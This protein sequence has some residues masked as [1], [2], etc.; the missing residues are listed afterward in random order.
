MANRRTRTDSTDAAVNAFQAVKNPSELIWPED[1]VTPMADPEKQDHAMRIAR[2][3]WTSR[4]PADW[5]DFD[6][7]QIAQ[8]AI[9][10]V[11]LDELQTMISKVGYVTRKKGGKGQDVIARN[12][13]L[14]PIVQLQNR[15]ITLARSLALTGAHIDGRT[16]S[17]AAKQQKATL[18][19]VENL[20]GDLLATPAK[21]ML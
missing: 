2:Q 11:D 7:T 5:K 21:A 9:T 13:L 15:Q 10:T 6:R 20:D 17:N 18:A 12:P 14:D 3:I 19:V 16:A 1:T 4:A 8:L